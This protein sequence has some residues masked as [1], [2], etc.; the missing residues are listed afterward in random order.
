M[1]L[2]AARARFR[3]VCVTGTNGKT[4]TTSMLAAIVEAAGEPSAR[5]TTLGSVVAGVEIAREATSRAFELAIE[6]AERA[7]VRT[8]AIE[9][10]SEALHAGFAASF[11]ADVAVFTNFSRDHLDAHGTPE[12]YLAA[13]AQ[14][15]VHAR[16]VA[17]FNAADAA[18]ALLDEITPPQV[19]RLAYAARAVDPACAAF[20]RSLVASRVVVERD[21]TRV[22]LE[23]SP[24]AESLGGALSLRVVGAVNAENALAAALAADAL[25]YDARAIGA[26]LAAFAGV[27]GR[28]EV[29]SRA[30]LVAIDYAHTPDALERTLAQARALATGRVLVVFGCGGDRDPGKRGEMG[31]VAARGADVVIVTTDNPRRERAED[32]ADAVCAGAKEGPGE[33]RR[34]PDRAAAIRAAIE[35]AARSDIVVVAGKG[36]ETVQL[37][38]ERETPFDDAEVARTAL[39]ECGKADD[40]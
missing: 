18:S 22:E 36:H 31:S 13:K 4:T 8:L 10:T 19:T 7:G 40:P 3:V 9:T 26:G 17:V 35:L 24:R 25:G 34:I 2:A 32:I 33:L 30:P 14:L 16:G 37:V 28:F 15:F 20:P 12:A 5:I 1:D 21:R 27:R 29:V 23:G 38:G 39:A 11:P 6:A